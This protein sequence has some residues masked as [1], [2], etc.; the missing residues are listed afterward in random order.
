MKDPE[1]L[2]ADL[3]SVIYSTA[4]RHG[5]MQTFNKLVSLHNHTTLVEEKV[6]IA[7]AL[8]NFKQANIIE[9]ALAMITSEHVRHQDVAYWVAYSFGNRYA[10]EATW[11]WFTKHWDWLNESLGSDMSFSRF[12]IYSARSYSD[13]KFI[14]VYQRFFKPRLT[15][16]LER[17]YHQGLEIM[18]WQ[19]AWRER[20][21]TAIKGFFASN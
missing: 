18:E 7:S 10:R 19:T 6:T 21:L 3:R 13:P 11:K 20:D 4:V 1:D 14:K 5:N 12:P 9:K 8:T 2:D 15:P 16:A 17:S